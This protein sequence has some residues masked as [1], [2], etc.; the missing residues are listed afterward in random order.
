MFTIIF[1]DE[2]KKGVIPHVF[3]AISKSGRIEPLCRS[4]RNEPD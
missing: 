3:S 1:L 2:E 4:K